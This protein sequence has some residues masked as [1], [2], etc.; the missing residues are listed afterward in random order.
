[1]Q[2]YPFWT[3]LQ[4][5]Y[6]YKI[7][8]MPCMIIK[9]DQITKVRLYISIIYMCYL[10]SYWLELLYFCDTLFLQLLLVHGFYVEKILFV[11]LKM[12]CNKN[13]WW[14]LFIIIFNK[15]TI[16]YK[17]FKKKHKRVVYYQIPERFCILYT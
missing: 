12:N 6:V 5:H 8:T 14:I 13:I 1:M 2:I 11:A 7:C 4:W 3:Q 15:Y 10:I 16:V 9:F 17:W